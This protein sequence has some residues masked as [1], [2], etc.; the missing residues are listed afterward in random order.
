MVINVSFEIN[1][2]NL[3]HFVISS[4]NELVILDGNLDHLHLSVIEI[5]I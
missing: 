5:G 3:N 4:R 2:I 1:Q